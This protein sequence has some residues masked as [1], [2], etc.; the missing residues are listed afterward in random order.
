MFG[1]T[2]EKALEVALDEMHLIEF[3]LV[4]KGTDW[5]V[6]ENHHDLWIATGSHAISVLK[7]IEVA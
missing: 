4:G 3:Y 1:Q 5:A 6:A 7:A 2:C